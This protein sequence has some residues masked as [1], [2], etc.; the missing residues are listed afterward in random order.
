M[1]D[2]G[3]LR[4]DEL[5]AKQFEY[6]RE[7][8]PPKLSDYKHRTAE[9]LAKDVSV[10]HDNMRKMVVE[11]DLMRSEFIRSQRNFRWWKKAFIWALLAT[12]AIIGL[13]FKTFAAYAI[14]GMLAN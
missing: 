2:K 3:L 9:Q 8:H 5:D 6:Y 7:S 4:Q 10:A 11:K 12:W 1:R 14:K 13:L